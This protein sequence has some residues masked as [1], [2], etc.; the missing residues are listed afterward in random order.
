ME[1]CSH[2]KVTR[3]VSQH[4][5]AQSRSSANVWWMKDE[6]GL[7]CPGAW[8]V[9]SWWCSQISLIFRAQQHNLAISSS[10]WCSWARIPRRAP[11]PHL[12]WPRHHQA[13]FGG[14][15]RKSWIHYY[16]PQLPRFTILGFPLTC[17][18]WSSHLWHSSLFSVPHCLTI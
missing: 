4:D 14:A 2:S 7:G 10:L 3:L 17:P 18:H 15:L 11:P 5:L 16:P 8:P 9:F 12:K 13:L 6:T 1:I